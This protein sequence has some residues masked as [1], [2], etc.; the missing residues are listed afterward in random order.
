MS[1]YGLDLPRAGRAAAPFAALAALALL[2]E[3][4]PRLP[5]IVGVASAAVFA[6]AAGV[7]AY[8][9]RRELAA[10]RVAAD[11]LILNAAQHDDGSV[12]IAWREHELVSRRE[13]ERL[14]REVERMLRSLDPA[15]LPSASP[16]KRTAAR[17][18]GDLFRRL[19]ERLGDGQPVMARGMLLAESLLRS[20]ASPLY[21]EDAAR[22]LPRALSRVLGALEP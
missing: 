12:L 3:A 21:D 9:A 16:L 11:R 17:A 22:L 10:V 1:T 7:R 18:N 19:D 15:R 6:A 20:P 5:W 4:D 2:F 13:R 14:R 8:V